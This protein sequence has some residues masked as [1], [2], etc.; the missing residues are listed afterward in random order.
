M[1]KVT[2]QKEEVAEA[3]MDGE[4][5]DQL[6]S[7]M[8]EEVEEAFDEE[9]APRRRFSLRNL[10]KRDAPAAKEKEEVAVEGEDPAPVEK[11]APVAGQ[12]ASEAMVKVT[13]Q[14][15]VLDESRFQKGQLSY[16]EGVI[17]YHQ[18]KFAEALRLF[19]EALIY[20]P[21]DP[22]VMDYVQKCRQILGYGG[23]TPQQ[24]AQWMGEQQDVM[25]QELRIKGDYHK[26]KA[27]GLLKSALRKWDADPG[28]D[29]AQKDLEE[30]RYEGRRAKSAISQLPPGEERLE[31]QEKI[32]EFLSKIDSLEGSWKSIVQARIE[33]EA[34]EKSLKLSLESK[35][36]DTA[37]LRNLLTQARRLYLDQK[38]QE[39]EDLCRIILEEW[40][41]S[42][43]ARIIL[44]KSIRRKDR[45]LFRELRD[46]SEEEW[47]RNIERVRDASIAYSEWVNYSDDWLE[48]EKKR[49]KSL[50]ETEEEPEWVRMMRQ[51][52]EQRVT[53]HL[54]DN[55]LE[56]ATN[57]MQD[58][59]GV[60]FFIDRSLDL[61]D[62]RIIELHLNNVRLSAALELVLSNLPTESPL[63]YQFRDEVVFITSRENQNLFNRPEQILYDVT[64]LVTTFGE[65]TLGEGEGL[66]TGQSLS[67]VSESS[68]STSPMSTETLV[69]LIQQ[70]IDPDSWAS[71]G[72][73]VT[74]YEAGKIL[75]SHSKD[76]HD[77]I[78]EL[79]DMFRRQQKLQVSIEARFITS[80]DDD[81]FDVGVEWKGLEEVQLEDTVLVGAGTFSK[82]TNINSD[83]RV[84]TI[85]GS[86]AD[87]VVA[88]GSAFISENRSSEGLNAEISVL[89][90]IRAA[91]V[92]HALTRKNTTKDL[93][94][95][96]LTVINNR[97]GYFL[98]SEDI[99]YIRN[100][101]S[102]DG[103][104]VPEIS[105]VSQGELLVVRPTVSSDR[106]YITLDLSPQVTRVLD[107]TQRSLILPA[108]R[109]G[110][111]NNGGVVETVSVF[112]ELPD[113]EVW[114]LQTRIQVPDGGVVFV[115]GR[116]GNFERENTRSVPV[117]SKIPFLGRLFRADGR[118][119]ELENLIISVRAKI[120][121]FEELESKLH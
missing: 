121:V 60:N 38:Y 32:S 8:K 45:K 42:A 29:G 108:D 86:A 114:Q 19:E 58:Q 97:Q 11:V 4:A 30:A 109:G 37:R 10:F 83:T 84:A 44:D 50:V 48:I 56:E 13:L 54:P 24:A 92:L 71:D 98:N 104:I 22:K 49:S 107:L 28:S 17:L 15:N 99:S 52:M 105:R 94:A 2:L 5:A 33:R 18:F 64:D 91:I 85:L 76:V 6:S 112:I 82:R 66:L 79:L 59:T 95:P 81:L 7:E 74:E 67:G 57:Q 41:K 72:V 90:P 27:F 12:D 63:V 119:V 87:A 62:A 9:P 70:A 100:F 21:E 31:L 68:E 89:D 117:I 40:P 35:Q 55:S 3:G 39:S 77:Q 53:L 47:R 36:Y 20:L 103:N 26:D 51:K 69:E 16:E 116:M 43:D 113:V 115:G 96:R 73:S 118:Y 110:N 101:T 61:T 111:G 120:L 93:L 1:V 46:R 65:F 80:T 34:R 25:L 78:A 88:G 106:K 102:E 23:Q 75:I 14:K